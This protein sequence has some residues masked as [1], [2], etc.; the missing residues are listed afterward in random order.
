MPITEKGTFSS[1]HKSEE[2]LYQSTR[3]INKYLLRFNDQLMEEEYFQFSIQKYRQLGYVICLIQ[4]IIYIADFINLFQENKLTQKY[5]VFFVLMLLIAIFLLL[6]LYF[7]GNWFNTIYSFYYTF[8][9]TLLGWSMYDFDSNQS[10]VNMSSITQIDMFIYGFTISSILIL[11]ITGSNYLIKNIL[12][13]Y[14]TILIYV[15]RAIQ[16]NVQYYA[17]IRVILVILLYYYVSYHREK[18]H[19]ISF[20]KQKQIDSYNNIMNNQIPHCLFAAKFNFK[21]QRIELFK[22]NSRAQK[23]FNVNDNEDFDKFISNSYLI[24]QH[25]KTEKSVASAHAISNSARQQEQSWENSLKGKI[26]QLIQQKEKQ[27]LQQLQKIKDGSASKINNYQ[28]EINLNQSPIIKLKLRQQGLGSDNKISVRLSIFKLHEYYVIITVDRNHKKKNKFKKEFNSKTGPNNETGIKIIK[29]RTQENIRYV[30]YQDDIA[31]NHETPILNIGDQI[32]PIIQKTQINGQIMSFNPDQYQIKNTQHL[33]PA[34]SPNFQQISQQQ[35]SNSIIPNSQKQ[36]PTLQA[37]L[38]KEEDQVLVNKNSPPNNYATYSLSV[39]HTMRQG[40]NPN[41]HSFNFG[42]NTP[43]TGQTNGNFNYQIDTANIVSI[44]GVDKNGAT[45]ITNGQRKSF[46]NAKTISNN[47]YLNYMTQKKLTLTNPTNMVNMAIRKPMNSINSVTSTNLPLSSSHINQV[48]N[49]SI[50]QYQPNPRISLGS[51]SNTNN[52]FNSQSG[53]GQPSNTNHQQNSLEKKVKEKIFDTCFEIIAQ[54]L[55]LIQRYKSIAPNFKQSKM[56]TQFLYQY[57]NQSTSQ[58]HMMASNNMQSQ[59]LHLNQNCGGKEMNQSNFSDQSY[60]EAFEKYTS[61][62]MQQILINNSNFLKFTRLVFNQVN[63][64]T[65]QLN[66]LDLIEFLKVQLNPILAEK[67]IQLYLQDDF[68]ATFYT[69][70]NILKLILMNLVLYTG[71]ILTELQYIGLKFNLNDDNTTLKVQ[72]SMPYRENHVFDHIDTL[73]IIAL[74]QIEK[75]YQVLHKFYVDL[76]VAFCMIKKLNYDNPQVEDYI[77]FTHTHPNNNH[78]YLTFTIPAQPF[79]PKSN[80]ESNHIPINENLHSL[81]NHNNPVHRLEENINLN[82]KD[83][84]NQRSQNEINQSAYHNMQSKDIRN[85]EEC[86]LD[87]SISSIERWVTIKQYT[88]RITDKQIKL[89]V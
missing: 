49:T 59:N 56:S 34:T 19:R 21:E 88:T 58:L 67:S 14:G 9:I 77:K 87:D 62:M 66:S 31:Q 22:C 75:D 30:T 33:Q 43:T 38:Q 11:G 54:T 71:N 69:D 61:C 83:F 48:R 37:Q 84:I 15:S 46:F 2:G 47:N 39:Q 82:E 40:Y 26:R 1:L 60:Y 85:T 8:Y 74:D 25:E 70:A 44:N 57:R 89:I 6:I 17:I 65:A 16:E 4:I 86:F 20:L 18:A 78:M 80:L 72:L 73:H 35:F 13:T 55:S 7:K 23:E 79:T 32:S 27:E 76:R 42:S 68:D 81:S 29:Q 51:R 12:F 36:S 64:K 3:E 45:N 5:V 53:G 50:D 52:N 28:S 10:A 41:N 63:V 24:H